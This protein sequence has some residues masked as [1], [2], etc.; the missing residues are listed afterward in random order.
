VTS[1]RPLTSDQANSAFHPFGVDTLSSKLLSNVSPSL[2]WRHLVNAYEVKALG[3]AYLI[4]LLATQR[5]LYLA[6]YSPVL[7]L[8]VVAVLHDR[9][10]CKCL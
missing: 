3:R 1:E 7:N 4:G 2:R 9:L 10:L 6:A 8:V 5:R